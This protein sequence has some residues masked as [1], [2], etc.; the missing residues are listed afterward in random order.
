MYNNETERRGG[1]PPDNSTNY[2][3]YD[4]SWEH[5]LLVKVKNQSDLYDPIKTS[6]ALDE[7]SLQKHGQH[8]T[9]TNKKRGMIVIKYKNKLPDSTLEEILS[10]KKIGNIEVSCQLAGNFGGTISGVIY[11]VAADVD[12]D[13]VRKNIKPVS[14]RM[15]IYSSEQEIITI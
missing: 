4:E 10:T 1:R 12:M 3:E 5:V 14:S 8:H 6:S 7:S 11:D 13:K 2:K 15:N 9:T